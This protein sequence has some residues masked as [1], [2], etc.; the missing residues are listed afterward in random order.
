M[1][2]TCIRYNSSFKP[3]NS[4][5]H[6]KRNPHMI[7]SNKV[8][9]NNWNH[10]NKANLYVFR[11]SEVGKMELFQTLQLDADLDEVGMTETC[12]RYNSSI[13]NIHCVHAYEKNSHMISQLTI[14]IVTQ[15]S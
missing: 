4:V 15:F 13:A 6:Y 2:K 1:T 14:F 3:I 8:F 10:L 9:H 7:S 12:I 11:R 5:H